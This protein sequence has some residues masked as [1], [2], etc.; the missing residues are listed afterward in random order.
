MG[1]GLL[2]DNELERSAAV[3]NCWMNWE[4]DLTGSNGYD[5]ELGFAPLDF[6]KGRVVPGRPAAWLDLCCGTGQALIQAARTAH[7]EGLDLEIVG[8][9]LVGMFHRADL[10]LTF[11]RLVEA[12]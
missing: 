3:A 9:D 10:D 4:R 6:L 2:S 8:L 7:A 1:M 11:L 12:S 5:R